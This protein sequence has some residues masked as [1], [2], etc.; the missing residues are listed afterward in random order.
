MILDEIQTIPYEYWQLIKNAFEAIGKHYNCYFIL[1]SA[2]QPLIFKP[3]DEII[4]I[5]PDYESYF[6]Y[7]NR[8][9]LFNRL[10]NIVTLDEFTD[11]VCEYMTENSKKDIA[12]G[13]QIRSYVLHPYKLVKDHR[14]GFH[15]SQAETVLDGDLD[16]YI[17]EYLKCCLTGLWAKGG[18]DQD[19]E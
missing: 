13:S 11:D 18:V 19:V 1:M 14:T 12:W 15:S 6:G 9:K 5:V 4:E 8:T 2:T 3:N 16:G 10:E 17:K 7:F